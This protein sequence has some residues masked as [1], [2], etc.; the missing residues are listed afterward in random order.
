MYIYCV[1]I[2]PRNEHIGQ[3]LDSNE[4]LQNCLTELRVQQTD[5]EQERARLLGAELD[6]QTAET[7][8]QYL[9]VELE[10]TREKLE[11]SNS[12]A[13]LYLPALYA[14]SVLYVL[15]ALWLLPSVESDRTEL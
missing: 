3:L 5:A 13:N 6:L 7:E 14:V 10:R 2:K 15:M 11:K 8:I 4:A 1:D 12:T 9:R